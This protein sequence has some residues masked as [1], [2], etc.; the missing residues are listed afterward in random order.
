MLTK[1]S[2]DEL[3]ENYT[4]EKEAMEKTIAMLTQ[5]NNSFK[6]NLNTNEKDK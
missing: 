1:K 3:N 2:L 4:K 5:E 6:E